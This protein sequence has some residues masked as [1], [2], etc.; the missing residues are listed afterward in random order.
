MASNG[1]LS[2]R[3]LWVTFGKIFAFA[4]GVALPLLLVRN[5]SQTGFG[6]YKQTFLVVASAI[7]LLP[8]GIHTSVYY[9]LSREPA[10]SRAIV[11]N[12]LLLQG[13]V[14][15]LACLS[16]MLFPG[17]MGSLFRSQ[18]LAGYSP[19][20]GAVIFFWSLAGLIETVTVAN[21]EVRMSATLT[22]A[23][24]LARAGMLVLA[25]VWFSTVQS[26]LNAAIL[27]GVMQTAILI[28]YLQTRFPGFWRTVDWEMLRAQISYALPIGLTGLMHSA[29]TDLHSFVVARQFPPDLYAI[30]AVGC[31]HIPLT[32]IM[33]ESVGIVMMPR[34]SMLQKAGEWNQILE[35]GANAVRKL[36]AVLFPIYAFLMAV[37]PDFLT[38][39]FTD[40]YKNSWQIF[41]INQTIVPFSVLVGDP[42][43]RV[44]KEQR[45]FLVILYATTMVGAIAGLWFATPRFGMIGAITTTVLAFALC[46]ILTTV[47]VIRV[48]PARWRDIR[49][50]ADPGKLAAASL[51]AGLAAWALRA[52]LAGNRQ[53]VILLLCGFGFSL[54]YAGLVAAWKVVRPEEWA[55]LRNQL[56][57]LKRGSAPRTGA[58]RT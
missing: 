9:Y 17:L 4:L 8:L 15:M 27:Y 44:F 41:A 1:S 21:E 18:E 25:A 58:S 2:V 30:Y 57:R 34:I 26:M 52:V 36:A 32:A 11:F 16:L 55:L 37:G 3:A 51:A 10:R 6:I 47:Q 39:L 40:R 29:Q 43:L 56:A 22:V 14:S 23:G 49:L 5:L 38:F 50:L 48:L 45:R 13:F 20:I 12:M 42:I 46:H 24:H 19:Y 35:I 33:T 54:V 7:V 28:W 31:F 53:W